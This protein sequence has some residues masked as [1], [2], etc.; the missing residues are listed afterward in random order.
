[1]R[2]FDEDILNFHEGAFKTINI[3][4]KFKEN[5]ADDSI[6]NAEEL[7]NCQVF[8]GTKIDREKIK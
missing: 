3:L 2:Q 8:D 7:L 4:S 6:D 1:L 5:A